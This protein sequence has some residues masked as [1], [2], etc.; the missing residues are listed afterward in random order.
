MCCQEN[1]ID[2]ALNEFNDLVS[3]YPF[4]PKLHYGLALL[5]A[6]AQDYKKAIKQ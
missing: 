1:K 2:N 4:N 6:Q 3:K 5:L